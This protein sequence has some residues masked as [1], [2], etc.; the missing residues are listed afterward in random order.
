M[1]RK[2]YPLLIIILGLLFSPNLQGHHDSIDTSRESYV[3]LCGPLGRVPAGES[4]VCTG[5]RSYAFCVCLGLV[6]CQMREYWGQ[7]DQDE[8]C[9]PE[10]EDDFVDHCTPAP[11][12]NNDNHGNDDNDIPDNG[13]DDNDESPEDDDNDGIANDDDNCP[14]RSNRD[15]S[16][17]DNDGVGDVCENDDDNDRIPDNRDNCPLTRNQDQRDTDQDGRG[18][19]CDEDDDNDGL[20][21]AR[22]AELGTDPL[23]KDTDRDGLTDGKEI[24][25][26]LNP[27]VSD[28]P[29]VQIVVG[30]LMQ[31][32]DRD[33]DGISDDSD[34]CPEIENP[35]QADDDNDGVGDLCE[36]AEVLVEAL[37]PFSAAYQFSS[38][39]I[40]YYYDFQKEIPE[41]LLD[42]YENYSENLTKIILSNSN[43]LKNFILLANQGS[44][45]LKNKD[46]IFNPEFI[47]EINQFADQLSD[48]GLKELGIQIKT[49]SSKLEERSF[50]EVLKEFSNSD[51]QK[52]EK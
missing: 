35:D 47:K 29:S 10:A 51:F 4:F 38:F 42:F 2:K 5:E 17:N 32:I 16:D 15:Q 34:N 39:P 33:G 43:L 1:N 44:F 36:A 20:S 21:D 27:L 30:L 23:H 11:P 40:S 26:R 41:E 28:N 14:N 31:K 18:D 37:C 7:C 45:Y 8:I 13:N 46:R 22:E 48:Q 6:G 25:M 19:V 3:G 49:Y 9:N 50:N 52:E 24:Q 12:N